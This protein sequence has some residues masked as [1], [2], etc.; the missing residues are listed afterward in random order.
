MCA[1]KNMASFNTSFRETKKR[2]VWKKEKSEKNLDLFQ[3]MV[4][5]LFVG[6]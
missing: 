4:Q 1:V 2:E 3:T 5:N 6:M